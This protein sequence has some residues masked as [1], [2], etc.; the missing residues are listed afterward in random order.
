M[1]FLSTATLAPTKIIVI[2][3]INIDMLLNVTGGSRSQGSLCF[4][5]FMRRQQSREAKSLQVFAFGYR[6]VERF[7]V[8]VV[9]VFNVL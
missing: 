6:V 3:N 8:V 4:A 2:F 1:L 7:I 9:V 5:A